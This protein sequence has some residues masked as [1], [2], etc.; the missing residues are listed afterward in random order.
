MPITIHKMNNTGAIT[1]NYFQPNTQKHAKHTCSYFYL[2]LERRARIYI[3][4]N[5][6]FILNMPAGATMSSRSGNFLVVISYFTTYYFTSNTKGHTCICNNYCVTCDQETQQLH[7]PFIFQYDTDVHSPA[8][9]LHFSRQREVFPRGRVDLEVAASRA[10]RSRTGTPPRTP[11][12]VW[13]D[14]AVKTSA[15][16]LVKHHRQN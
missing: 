15:A 6:S 8:L 7:A 2:S 12:G 4:K 16:P 3:H 5:S 10:D 14:V 11:P 1:S 13:R 9:A